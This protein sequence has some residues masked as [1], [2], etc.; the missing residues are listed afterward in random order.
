[1]TARS[2]RWSAALWAAFGAVVVIASWRLDRLENL[3]INPWSAPG[4]TP[5]VVGLLMILL[6][7]GLAIQ[8]RRPPTVAAGGG[9]AGETGAIGV[10][11]V[12]GVTGMTG[13][14]GVPGVPGMTGVTGVTEIPEATDEGDLSRTLIATLLC[15]LFAGVSLGHGLPFVV[16][17]A[18]FIL[19]FVAVFS[20]KQWRAEGRVGR[21]LLVTLLIASASSGLISWLFESVFLVRLP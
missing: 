1:V 10:T 15:V 5:G 2:D 14:T 12:T 13:V 6:A 18:A 4:L 20:W 9:A 11:G 19:V 17:G 8:S 16:E 21:G 7:A 3:H